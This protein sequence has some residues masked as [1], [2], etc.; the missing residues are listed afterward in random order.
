[1]NTPFN[2]KIRTSKRE[3]SRRTIMYSCTA[4]LLMILFTSGFVRVYVNTYNIM[5][6]EPMEVFAFS[7]TDSGAELVIFNHT[8]SL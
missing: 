3:R 2:F 1:M 6:S 5:H 4:A 8:F 7:Q